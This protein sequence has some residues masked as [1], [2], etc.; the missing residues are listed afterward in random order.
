MGI[1]YGELVA[2]LTDW[3][4]YYKEMRAFLL[5]AKRLLKPGGVLA[6]NVPKEVRLRKDVIEATGRRV[7][8]IS[9][10]IDLMC[11][12]IGLLPRESIVWVKGKNEPIA[13]TTAMGAD[14]NIYIRPVCEMILL[15]SKDRYHYDNGTGRR[16]SKDVPFLDETKDV[17]WN[18]PA[19]RR[20]HPAPFPIEIPRRL[21]QMFTCLKEGQPPPIIFDPFMGSGTT[22]V[23]ARE[24][25][26]K[27]IGIDISRKYC[28]IAKGKLAQGM[29]FGVV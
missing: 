22:L 27:S 19:H 4:A 1:D 13:T 17:W 3:G 28:E 10:R 25:G 15:H 14:N 20:E 29:M 8:K 6:V 5:E 24:L 16:G 12:E 18:I 21:I 26:R 9:V 2:D 11:E 7:E 23:A